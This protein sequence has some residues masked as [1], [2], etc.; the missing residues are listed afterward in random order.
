MPRAMGTVR[1][2]G[3]RASRAASGEPSPDRAGLAARGGVGRRG[4]P[5][6]PGPRDGGGAGAVRLA[7]RG[8]GTAHDV[9]IDAAEPTQL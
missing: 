6:P 7:S 5:P 4:R 1:C 9:G 3:R 8:A 2:A